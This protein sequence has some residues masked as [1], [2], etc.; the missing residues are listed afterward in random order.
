MLYP[1][2]YEGSDGAT[3][4]GGRRRQGAERTGARATGAPAAVAGATGVRHTLTVGGTAFG[5]RPDPA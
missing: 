1:L 3:M 4:A 2:S 5:A